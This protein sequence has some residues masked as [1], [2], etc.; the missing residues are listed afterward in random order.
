[1][2]GVAG[3]SAVGPDLAPPPPAAA[4]TAP[5]IKTLGCA[6]TT[7]VN[8]LVACLSDGAPGDTNSPVTLLEWH[9]PTGAPDTAFATQVFAP[10]LTTIKGPSDVLALA[11]TLE[12]AAAESYVKYGSL[13][14]DAQAVAAFASI[15]PV[16][17]QHVS[18]ILSSK[19]LVDAGAPQLIAITPDLAKLPGPA[20]SVGFP[21]SFYKTDHARPADEGKVA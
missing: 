8:Q 4:P 2:P 9:A 7:K 18:V 12:Q 6:S 1:M 16:E 5:L 15:A 3:D 11:S 13:A 20:G 21:D 19:A 10:A 17:A 14:D